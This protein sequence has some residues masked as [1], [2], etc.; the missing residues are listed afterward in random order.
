[1]SNDN[2]SVVKVFYAMW[3]EADRLAAKEAAEYAKKPFDTII[4]T[5]EITGDKTMHIVT[6]LEYKA[7]VRGRNLMLMANLVA[8]KIGNLK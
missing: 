3:L 5:D 8:N 1:M 4:K 2:E 6:E 7:K